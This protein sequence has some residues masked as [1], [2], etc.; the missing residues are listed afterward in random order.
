MSS[1]INMVWRAYRA[2]QWAR[3]AVEALATVDVGEAGSHS[4]AHRIMHG[5][6]LRNRAVVDIV[7]FQEGSVI[8]LMS[9]VTVRITG[10][11]EEE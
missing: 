5:R 2:R 3:E 9:T 11:D 4:P 6:G 7:S 8:D 10:S 1:D